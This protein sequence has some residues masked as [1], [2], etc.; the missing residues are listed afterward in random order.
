MRPSFAEGRDLI[1]LALYVQLAAFTSERTGF[2]EGKGE[3]G[4][5]YGSRSRPQTQQRR[6]G[7]RLECPCDGDKVECGVYCNFATSISVI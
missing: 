1:N 3:C 5:L 2:D 6:E 7:G 4:L